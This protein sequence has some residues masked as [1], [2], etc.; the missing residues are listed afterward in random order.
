[1]GYGLITSQYGLTNTTVLTAK[2]QEAVR[3]ITVIKEDD[4]YSFGT[5][6]LK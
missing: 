2:G 1:M 3:D 5:V 4:K 6:E